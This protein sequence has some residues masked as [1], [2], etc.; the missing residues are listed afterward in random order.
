MT[1]NFQY[2]IFIFDWKIEL[3]GC[4][5]PKSSKTCLKTAA[6]GLYQR[7]FSV[8]LWMHSLL[9][10]G[11]VLH[12]FVKYIW[13]NINFENILSLL[14]LY[15]MMFAKSKD[16]IVIS[17]FHWEFFS[18]FTIWLSH[19][20]VKYSYFMFRGVELRSS[21]INPDSTLRNNY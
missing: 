14:T 15:W 9:L 8:C 17:Y 13:S 5:P 11:N 18:Y 7:L 1:I 19:S 12:K 4:N 2:K 20:C 10:K 3:L 6:Y 21:I 16:I